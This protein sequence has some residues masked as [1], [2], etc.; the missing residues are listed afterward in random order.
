MEEYAGG[1]VL[2]VVRRIREKGIE[3]DRLTSLEVI[4]RLGTGC[5]IGGLEDFQ[6]LRSGA[7]G[8]VHIDRICATGRY[9][10]N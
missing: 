4:P 8:F 5:G 7:T 10:L 1:F 2:A 9:D 6:R 3:A